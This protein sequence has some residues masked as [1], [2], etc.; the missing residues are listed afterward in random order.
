MATQG[1]K[2][3]SSCLEI[4]RKLHP[5]SLGEEWAGEVSLAI[6]LWQWLCLARVGQD[7]DWK[8][9]AYVIHSR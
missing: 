8:G 7:I 3:H 1:G 5:K 6:R 2:S 4:L 9:D